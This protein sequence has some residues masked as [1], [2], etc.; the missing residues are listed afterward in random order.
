MS[1]I[2]NIEMSKKQHLIL[3]IKVALFLGIALLLKT[4]LSTPYEAL[5][6]ALA[7][8]FATLTLISSIKWITAEISV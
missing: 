3:G 6:N 7:T 4:H 5:N 8:V 2:L 1:K